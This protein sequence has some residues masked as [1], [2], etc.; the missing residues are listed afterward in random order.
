MI[1]VCCTCLFRHKTHAPQLL[2]GE[3]AP[4]LGTFLDFSS[5][6]PLGAAIDG[7]GGDPPGLDH[8]LV[9]I[10]TSDDGRAEVRSQYAC[11]LA[12]HG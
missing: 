4:V 1:R 9:R 12:H 2:T 5:E 11:P 10:G 3:V 8:C 6:K 7:M